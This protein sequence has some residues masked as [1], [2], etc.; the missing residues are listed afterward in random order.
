MS[1]PVVHRPGTPI[2]RPTALQELHPNILSEYADP[3]SDSSGSTS[4]CACCASPSLPDLETLAE[5]IP[6]RELDRPG[7][8]STLESQ[9]L[10]SV[11]LLPAAESSTQAAAIVPHD[12]QASGHWLLVTLLCHRVFDACGDHAEIRNF[13]VF[14]HGTFGPGDVLTAIS[15]K[16]I[17]D[18]LTWLEATVTRD[19][20]LVA[21]AT[22]LCDHA[23]SHTVDNTQ[24]RDSDQRRAC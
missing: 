16:V 1:R 15:R 3:P 17:R 13:G 12:R 23:H 6:D 24:V 11:S 14:Y 22:A 4:E 5:A 21:T 7:L 10:D 8:S 18:R 19:G 2:F 20:A 9:F